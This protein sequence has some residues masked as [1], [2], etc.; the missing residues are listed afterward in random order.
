MPWKNLIIAR[1]AGGSGGLHGSGGQG[2]TGGS[3]GQGRPDGRYGLHGHDGPSAMG[4]AESGYRG[5]ITIQSTE[6]FFFY[7][8]VEEEK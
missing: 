8:T 5:E 1:S 6:E 3:G 2:G 4:S 7:K